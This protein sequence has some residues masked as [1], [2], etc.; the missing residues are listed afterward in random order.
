[1]SKIKAQLNS[2]VLNHRQLPSRSITV[3]AG[4]SVVLYEGPPITMIHVNNLCVPF[5]CRIADMHV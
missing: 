4:A 5:A 3:E 1:M 2:C